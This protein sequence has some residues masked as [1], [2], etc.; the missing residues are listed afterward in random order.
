MQV[1][2]GIGLEYTY[3]YV[4]TYYVGIERGKKWTEIRIDATCRSWFIRH[5]GIGGP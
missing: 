4:K 1:I 5:V 3:T 2:I